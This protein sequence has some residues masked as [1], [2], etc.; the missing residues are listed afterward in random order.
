MQPNHLNPHTNNGTASPAHGSEVPE[1]SLGEFRELAELLGQQLGFRFP[2]SK[3]KLVAARLATRLRDLGL[4]SYHDYWLILR[5]PEEKTELQRA[6]DLVTTNET[7]FFREPAHFDFLRDELLPPLAKQ[8]A[9]IRIWSAACSTG[10][11]P[12]SIAMTLAETLGMQSDW[13]VIATDVSERVLA[14]ARHGLYPINA[15]EQIPSGLLKKYCL[16]GNGEYEGHFLIERALR[17]RVRFLQVNLMN[18]LDPALTHFDGVF[19]RNVMIYL[20]SDRRDE[21]I[22]RLKSRINLGG[23]LIVGQTESM[24]IKTNGLSM[25]QPSIYMRC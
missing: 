20:E 25:I 16:K 21:M 14:H 15:A 24:A 2:D 23:Y 10:Q 7:F 3:L 5:H 22:E 12:Y 13:L 19:L 11:E 8:G 18:A 4:H 17:N 9:S 6:I 1:L